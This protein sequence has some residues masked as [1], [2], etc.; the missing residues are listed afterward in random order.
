MV[1]FKFGGTLF[2]ESLNEVARVRYMIIDDRYYFKCRQTCAEIPEIV[3]LV[4][5]PHASTLRMRIHRSEK[6]GAEDGYD[7]IGRKEVS[8][9]GNDRSD[10]RV[11]TSLEIEIVPDHT[12]AC[13]SATVTDI[14]AGGMRIVPDAKLDVGVSFWTSLP[15][16]PKDTKLYG[17]IRSIVPIDRLGKA[18]YGC[19][20]EH[21]SSTTKDMIRGY[22]FRQEAL[23]RKKR[24]L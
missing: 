6:H 15:F 23:N 4:T 17:V 24:I 16:L 1:E 9:T 14:S 18:S 2:D 5:D 11:P 8:R 22:V 21:I 7:L 20:F 12:V 19:E 10:I 3:F 13:I